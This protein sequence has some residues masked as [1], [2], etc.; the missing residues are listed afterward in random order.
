[1]E[2]TLG[3]ETGGVDLLEVVWVEVDV[4]VAD[5]V[6]VDVVFAN[7]V[8]VDVVKGAIVEVVLA[9]EVVID[10]CEV[11]VGMAVFAAEVADAITPVAQN[12]STSFVQQA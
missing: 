5:V 1:M 2:M 6:N 12:S 10:E 9:A 8:D 11:G 4:V 3:E 7:V